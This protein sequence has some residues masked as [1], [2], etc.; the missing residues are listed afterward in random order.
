MD[1]LNIRYQFNPTLTDTA[2]FF[3]YCVPLT[4]ENVHPAADSL[5]KF[6]DFS[7]YNYI[8]P[9]P[10]QKELLRTISIFSPHKL[11]PVHPG[12]VIVNRQSTDWI[13]VLLVSCLFIFAWMQTFYSKRLSQ[14]FRAV[15]QAHSVNQLERE[16][17][18]FSE[19][20]TLGLGFIYYVVGSIFTFQLF[21]AYGSLPPGMNNLTFTAIIFGSLFSYQMLKSTIV[22]S[23]GYVFNN[24]ET[25]RAYQL[26][27]LI[28]NNII[29]I[30]L[31]PVII[32]AFYWE[33]TIFLNIGVVIASL[34][35]LYSL[36]RGILT[37]LANKNY[38]LFYLFLYLCTLE[39][40]PILLLY[41]VISK[42]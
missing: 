24:K 5:K 35:L 8:T 15:A 4:N 32:M 40:L 11:I 30:V 6:Y 10:A 17:N 3:D 31:F 9:S 36:F 1:S 39:I 19:R 34:L 12:P 42:I 41:K 14:I 13:T 28:F 21:S 38:N 29:G 26:N 20:I 37:G 16:G 2:G 7:V 33:S 27:T 22:Y 25:A 18:L 23:L